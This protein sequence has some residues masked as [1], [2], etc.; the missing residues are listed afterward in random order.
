MYVSNN[1]Y[2]DPEIPDEVFDE[3]R[4]RWEKGLPG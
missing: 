1:A 4:R 2:G 3:V